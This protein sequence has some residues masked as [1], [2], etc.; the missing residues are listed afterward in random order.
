MPLRRLPTAG[1]ILCFHSLTTT[2]LPAE[3]IV[4]LPLAA[5]K[6]IIAAVRQVAEI[7]PLADLVRRHLDGRSTSGLV[8]VTFDDAY[9]SLLTEA[10][11]FLGRAAIPVT[12]FVVT[13]A[14]STGA[15]YWWDRIDEVFPHV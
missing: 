2:R 13:N 15:R 4:H 11:D 14:A 1:A 8:A 6:R 3:G 10:E 7:V 12:V 5:F 9:A